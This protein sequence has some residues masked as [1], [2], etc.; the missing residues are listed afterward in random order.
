MRECGGGGLCLCGGDFCGLDGRGMPMFVHFFTVAISL[1][2]FSLTIPP[3]PTYTPTAIPKC[4]EIIPIIVEEDIILLNQQNQ[5]QAHDPT[6]LSSTI[7]PI[8]HVI[9]NHPTRLPRHPPLPRVRPFKSIIVAS[10]VAGET[11]LG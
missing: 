2:T 3:F 6:R 5:Y 4:Q 10:M 9:Q 7:N 11:R 8:Y 1:L